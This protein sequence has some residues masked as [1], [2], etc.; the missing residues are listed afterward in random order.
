MK[1]IPNKNKKINKRE[2]KVNTIMAIYTL[3]LIGNIG[4]L[5]PKNCR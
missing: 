3:Y 5:V 1:K 4:D 2:C